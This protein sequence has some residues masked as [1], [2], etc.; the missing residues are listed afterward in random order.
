MEQGMKSRREWLASVGA[1]AA[2]GVCLNTAMGVEEADNPAANV[3][4]KITRLTATPVR[5]KVF[6]KLETNHGVT[7]WGEIDQL[8]PFVAAQLAR[9]LFELLDGENPTRIEHLWQKIY[10]SHRDMRGGPFMTHTLAGID[11]ALWDITGKLWGVP[12]Y[13]LLG[14][15]TRDKLRVY[16]SVKATKTAANSDDRSK[17]CKRP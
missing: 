2:S 4:I 11:M 10:R 5:R 15:P 17:R 16:P 3:A 7:G 14:G 12:V 8:E 13:R 9:S 1:M 6:L